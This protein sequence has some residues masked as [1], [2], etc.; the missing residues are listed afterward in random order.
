MITYS[1]SDEDIDYT[2]QVYREALEFLAQALDGVNLL[3][4]LE[5]RPI[6]PIF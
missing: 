6:Q 4:A 3:D 1:H 5:G 2:L